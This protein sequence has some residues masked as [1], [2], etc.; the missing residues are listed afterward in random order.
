MTR[1]VVST[2]WVMGSLR[3][4]NF[5]I[6]DATMP[7]P[8]QG[9]D[10]ERGFVESHIPG[11]VFVDIDECSNSWSEYPHMLASAPEFARAMGE[12]GIGDEPIIA[13]DRHGMFSAARFWWMM[14]CYSHSGAAVMDGGLP[15]WLGENKPTER[16]TPPR[17]PRSF[18]LRE[19]RSLVASR[20]FVK[21]AISRRGH[22]L[23]D[24]RSP[25]RYAGQRAEP[26]KGLR[27]GHIP[28]SINIHYKEVLTADSCFKPK[29]ELKVLF[30]DRGAKHS[31]DITVSCGSGVTAAIVALALQIADYP[32]VRVYDGS[33]A[34]WG[35]RRDT[36]IKIGAEP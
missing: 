36:P 18:R 35:A 24:A 14:R 11:A 27:R 15:K 9:G 23:I 26:R 19:D 28:G 21:S 5:T 10:S 22:L 13:Y 33:W 1:P 4:D 7:L 31:H 25:G 2:D 29:N 6:V 12:L 30:K 3:L 17:R 8:E 32:R 16:G 20:H 34:E